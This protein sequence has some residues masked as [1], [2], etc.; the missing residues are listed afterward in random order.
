MIEP[1]IICPSCKQV[2]KLTESLAAP[3]V[4]KTRVEY[5]KRLAE[6]EAMM[7]RREAELE[8]QREQLRREQTLIEE[9]IAHEVDQRRKEIAE[10]E[11][12]RVRRQMAQDLESKQRDLVEALELLKKRE[13]QLEEAKRAEAEF[14]RCQRDLEDARR[15]LEVTVARRVA[16]SLDRERERARREAEEALQLKVAE[17]DH[18][19]ATMQH[20]IEELK[21]RAERG[22]EQLRGEVLELQ[23]EELLRSR[24]PGDAIEPVG[25]GEFGGDLL[26]R[27]FAGGSSVS[28]GTI[29]WEFKRTKNWNDAWLPKLRQDQ[30]A[31]QADL[32][33]IVSQTLPKGV[34][35][36]EYIDQI[37]VVSPR[38]AAP[39]AT[40]LRH[41]LVEVAQARLVHEDR[42]SKEALLYRYL[43]GPGFRHRFQ[44]LLEKFRDLQD[45]LDK[46]K[47]FMQKQWSK[48]EKQL[49]I[50]DLNMSGL[51]GDLEGIVGRSLPE[52]EGLSLEDETDPS[53]KATP[54]L[55][56]DGLN[57]AARHRLALED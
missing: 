42:Q 20:Q 43:T 24:F 21:R 48:R 28:R 52:I 49:E 1:T 47:K 57:H 25:K 35:G 51:Y 27:V 34:E 46:E 8:S 41:A 31:A 53:S 15:E 9:R 7:T 17:K 36:F 16:E 50:I 5:Q 3:L 45:D 26:Q 2:I 55:G 13:A 40:I 32:A 23:F 6:L 38:L 54:S 12:R 30:R 44:A 29:L 39:L 22:S 19:I 10:E 11:N 56:G 37:W 4:E 33:V 18:L 14:L